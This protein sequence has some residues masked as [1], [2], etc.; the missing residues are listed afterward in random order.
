MGF[1]RT[2]LQTYLFV[3]S[4]RKPYTPDIFNDLSPYYNTYIVNY[5]IND[6]VGNKCS[7]NCISRDEFTFWGVL[8]RRVSCLRY[9]HEVELSFSILIPRALHFFLSRG[10]RNRG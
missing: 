7:I 2:K 4:F 8:R 10:R 3:F 9:N 5:M 6:Q 1:I